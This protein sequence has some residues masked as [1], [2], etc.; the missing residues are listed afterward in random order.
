MEKKQPCF[1][2][3][4]KPFLFKRQLEVPELLLSVLDLV[5]PD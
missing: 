5:M 2:Q 3:A 4:E 1:I